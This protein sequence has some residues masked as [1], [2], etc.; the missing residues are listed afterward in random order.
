MKSRFY[1]AS[2]LMS[3]E[4]ASFGFRLEITG[5]DNVCESRSGCLRRRRVDR[6]K[7]SLCGVTT[8]L[9][10]KEEDRMEV[11]L[12]KI[13]VVGIDREN[14]EMTVKADRVLSRCDVIIGYDV[15]VDLGESIFPAIIFDYA[16]EAGGE[17][18]P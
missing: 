2:R 16:Y 15:Y 14:T 7:R 18:M 13:Y 10:L 12:N 5:A 11:S 4:G 1:T 6:Q 9:A 8:A 3:L 17:K